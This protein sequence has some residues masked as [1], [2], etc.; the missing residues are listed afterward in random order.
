GLEGGRPLACLL[1]ALGLSGGAGQGGGVE[2]LGPGARRLPVL[3]VAVGE[4]EHGAEPRVEPLAL[5]QLRAGLGELALLHQRARVAVERLGGRLAGG[6]PRGT[7]RRRS[8]EER[9]H[10][11]DRQDASVT[12]ICGRRN[13]PPR[14]SV[15]RAPR[16]PPAPR[17]PRASPAG[18]AC[19]EAR[20]A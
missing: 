12:A 10:G 18:R 14:P 5:G 4:V 19:Y 13:H 20:R 3:L 1:L 8:S 11:A 15:S 17:S 9:R 6:A 7:R 2:E 16:S